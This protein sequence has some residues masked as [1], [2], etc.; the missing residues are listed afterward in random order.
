MD[1]PYSK[2]ELPATITYCY[3]PPLWSS[4]AD[5]TQYLTTVAGYGKAESTKA[6]TTPS[7]KKPQPDVLYTPRPTVKLNETS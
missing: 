5:Y 3:K 2:F 1:T 4:L 7:S 6:E